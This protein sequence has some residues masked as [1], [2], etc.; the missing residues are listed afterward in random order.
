MAGL[1]DGKVAVVTGASSGISKETALLLARE[2]ARVVMADV[3]RQG[4]EET[5]RTATQKGEEAVFLHADVSQAQQVKRLMAETLDTFGK[6]DVLVNGAGR[7]VETPLLAEVSEEEWDDALGLYLRGSFLCCKFAIPVMLRG[8]RGSI[9]NISLAIVLRG[10]TFSLPYSVA[11]AGVVQL[12]KGASSQYC[13][14]GIRVNCV[15]PGV[16][17]TPGSR[18]VSSSASDRGQI[19]RR[20]A[21]GTNR[22]AP[23]CSQDDPILSFR[24][25]LVRVR[26]L[27]CH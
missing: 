17:D 14:Q 23:G 19:C 10:S 6:L 27:L 1:L 12:T 25:V 11:K 22:R 3:D 15:M 2:G 4:G 5:A 26:L 8:G 24:G 13:S 9:I 16:V 18:R 21:C 7:Q 20:R